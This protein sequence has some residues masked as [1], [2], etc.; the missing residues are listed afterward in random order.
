MKRIINFS[1]GRSSALMTILEYNPETD[2]VLFCD[3]GREHPK[4]Y[5]FIIDFEAHEGIP[6]IK[7][8]GKKGE[9]VVEMGSKDYF[10]EMLEGY[11]H[12]QIP[13]M[14]KRFCTIDLKIKP[15]R[16]WARRN[17]GMRY[18]NMIGFRSDEHKRK[19]DQHYK[20]VP[21]AYPLME[22]GINKA[23][24]NEYWNEKPY[25]LEMPS[26]LGNCTLC[27]MK[28][29]NAIISI[30]K[31][32]PELADKYIQDESEAKKSKGHTYLTGLSIKQCL[33][34]AQMPDLFSGIDLNELSPAYSCNC[35]T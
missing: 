7:I 6:I 18:V 17:I 13:N 29:K 35:H 10:G 9:A 33:D 19:A 5:K 4:T 32:F 30:L 15:A 16:R 2:Y 31:Q 26:I 14:A 23:A 12:K 20:Q 27:F 28:G 3:T 25:R 34:I 8:G 1:G 21:I 24:V 11:N 22:R